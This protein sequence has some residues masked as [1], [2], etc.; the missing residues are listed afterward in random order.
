MILSIIIPVYNTEKF[1]EKCIRSCYNQ[2]AP[3]EQY[4]LV[5]I[6]D[7]STDGSLDIVNR[8]ASE[9]SNIRV[10]S[11]ANAGLS[12]ARNAGMDAAQGDYCMFLD[13]DDWLS[14][15]CLKR[16]FNKLEAE[17]PDCL[18]I[19]AA[20]IIDGQAIRRFS[21]S[22][23]TPI[24]GKDFL[25]RET[26]PC[27]PFSLWKASFLKSNGLR[28]LEGIF[29]E[30]F[31]FTPRAY[32]L[33]TKMSRL[34]DLVYNVYQNPNSITRSV[35]YKKSFDYIKYV[36][37]NLFT[38]SESV[39]DSYKRVFYNLISIALNN[40]LDGIITAPKEIQEDLN[41]EIVARGCFKKA[42]KGCGLSKYL[43]EYI[44]FSIMNHN[45]IGAFKMMRTIIH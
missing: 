16:I 8:L 11:Q 23:E 39:E 14:S 19:C 32:Y 4:E 27:A 31:E 42:L 33:A 44:L 3:I 21:Y 2:E 6:N 45:P 30:D 22:A 10:F 38:F 1:V 36:C 29:H 35:N 28:F 9:Y 26:S 18:G 12:A 17:T 25:T 40:A 7:G 15:N 5:V 13:S 41:R 24:A 37:P 43:I 34:N 20:N